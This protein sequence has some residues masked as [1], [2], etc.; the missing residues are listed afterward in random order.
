MILGVKGLN[1][2]N[3][4]VFLNRVHNINKKK[5]KK[6]RLQTISSFWYC[7]RFMSMSWDVKVAPRV[8]S[9]EEQR[10]LMLNKY[11]FVYVESTCVCYITVL[12]SKECF[13][14]RMKRKLVRLV[15]SLFPFM[16]IILNRNGALSIF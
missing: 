9:S 6:R 1:I 12:V 8:M 16:L 10:T 4:K 7:F 11:R 2:K 13:L 15:F 14:N 5:K 3:L